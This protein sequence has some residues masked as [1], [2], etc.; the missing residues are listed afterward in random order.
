VVVITSLTIERVG[1][2]VLAVPPLCRNGDLTVNAAENAKLIRHIEAGGVD[3]LIYGGNANFYHIGA[4]GYG[5]ILA[6][7]ESAAGAGTLVI[8]S[9]GP[10]FGTMI[11]QAKIVRK[12]RFPTVMV[13]PMQGIATPAGIDAGLRHFVQAAGVPV[14]L[15][16]R[17]E[18]YVD[19]ARIGK[20]AAD[21]IICAVKYAVVRSN[22]ADDTYLRAICDALDRRIVIS[23]LGEQPAIVHMRDFGVG[24]FTAGVVCVAPRIS[25]A[26][27]KAIRDRNWAE[28]QRLRELCRPLE[29]LRNADSPIRVLHE[30]VRLAGIAQTGPMLPLLSNVAESEHPRI[31]EAALRL[32]E[33]DRKL[34][35][36]HHR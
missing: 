32:L 30:A 8:P 4:E 1:S 16:L 25:H 18:G 7:L 3:T 5:D 28:A 19:P 14:V 23:G 17:G 21:R 27:L 34:G 20:L 31:R 22:P 13:L 33:E 15:Y 11:E 6:M 12:H 24:G 10:T 2:S 36:G 9:V 29:D 35:A 26:M